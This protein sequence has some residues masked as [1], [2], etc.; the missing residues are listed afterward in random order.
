[1]TITEF[2]V[3]EEVEDECLDISLCNEDLFE[4]I[5]LVAREYIQTNVLELIN[6]KFHANL[7]ATLEDYFAFVV[8]ENYE[9][10]EINAKGLSHLIKTVLAILFSTYPPRSSGNTYITSV[11]YDSIQERIKSVRSKYQPE[12]RTDEWY[13]FRHNLITAS[14][15]HKIFEG[16]SSLNSIIYEKCKPIAKLSGGGVVNVD[17]PLHWGQK[18]EPVSVMLYEKIYDTSVEDFGCVS[19][20]GYSFLGASP[21]GI[22]TDPSRSRYGRMLE[23]K[24]IVNREISGIPK[25]EYWI[26]MQLQMEVCDFDE[27]DFLETKFVEYENEQSYYNDEHTTPVNSGIIVYFHDAVQNKPHYVYKPLAIVD[28][29]EIDQW[30]NGVV[31]E[32]SSTE[33]TWIRTIYWKLDIISCVLVLRN[34]EWFE[35][36]IHSIKQTWDIIE[37]ERI[38]GYDHRAPKRRIK[39]IEAEKDICLFN[40]ERL[41]N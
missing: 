40:V 18:Y 12:Q 9:L 13:T 8:F 27:C 21:D 37:K 31:N 32:V 10:S 6:P 41:P 2:S 26:Q 7:Q 33:K 17:S 35:K 22:N 34:K 4:S 30:E 28:K 3:R 14:N 5:S 23:I 25:K 24:N 11:N 16:E 19:H 36:C 15:A 39:K 1:M 20:E 29:V 38:S